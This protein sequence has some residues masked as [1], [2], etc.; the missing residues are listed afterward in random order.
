MYDMQSKVGLDKKKKIKKEGSANTVG[1]SIPAQVPRSF[2]VQELECSQNKFCSDVS[3]DKYPN[4]KCIQKYWGKEDSTVKCNAKINYQ[5]N[6]R[7]YHGAIKSGKAYGT[8]GS[9]ASSKDSV[10]AMFKAFQLERLA[11]VQKVEHGNPPGQ[12][13]EPHAV[14]DA[15]RDIVKNKEIANNTIEITKIRVE[16]AAIANNRGRAG[17]WVGQ[18][19]PKCLTCASW[20]NDCR[21]KDEMLPQK[22]IRFDSRRIYNR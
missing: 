16:N 14:G 21:V 11:G 7:G 13:A 8:G 4:S 22:P 9:D 1:K 18:L 6:R 19:K 20:I 12:C 17:V 10:I 3:G 15:L 5:Y 2:Y